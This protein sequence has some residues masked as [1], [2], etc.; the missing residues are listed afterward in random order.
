MMR[1]TYTAQYL[2]DS[3]SPDVRICIGGKTWHMWGRKGLER[4]SS[5]VQNIP[6]DCLP[7]LIGSGIGEALSILVEQGRPVAVIDVETTIHSATGLHKKY[8]AHPH[9]FWVEENSAEN[10]MQALRQW[11]KAHG[12][13]PLQP[14]AI[15]LYLRL[16]REYYG[17]L[18]NTIKSSLTYDFWEAAR[19][20]K[21]QETKPR[22]LF[23]DSDYFL[24]DEITAALKRLEVPFRLLTLENTD[25][26][27]Q[28]FIESLLRAVVDFKP[29]YVLTVN[30]FGLD[31]DGKLAELLQELQLPLASWFVDNPHL[32]LHEYAHPATQNTVIFTYDAGNEEMLRRKGFDNVHY[33]PLATDPHRFTPQQSKA[34]PT[35]WIC[36]VSFV[37]NSMLSAVSNSLKDA[38]LPAQLQL[39][40][41]TV[42]AEFGKSGELNVTA[43]LASRYP[44]WDTA[45]K[46]MAATGKRL[47]LESLLTWEATRQYRLNCVRQLL[48]FCPLIVGDNGWK[49]QLPETPR[50]RHLGAIDYYKELPAFY[51]QSSINF[52][53]TSQQMKGAVNQRVFDVPATGSFLITDHREQIENLFEIGTEVVV[54]RNPEEIP[55]LIKEYLSNPTART[56][57][58]KAARRRILAEHTYEVRLASIIG[59]MRKTFS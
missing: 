17:T 4:E 50:W 6:E 23:I 22:V 54:Y 18:V 55:G 44:E 51:Q 33:M 45:F 11:Q 16:N 30:H 34:T 3:S 48:D 29:D 35:D 28:S 40:Y 9:V 58:T 21:F 47:A 31:R 32:I 8:S 12:S 42:A 43:F 46:K 5:L 38:E 27:T 25:V 19:Y 1:E 24:C 26:G 52:N 10:A 2:E 7:V 53:C 20:P 36:D 41:E 13:A 49:S 39:H 57:I 37:G 56:V 14:I 15:P 59:I